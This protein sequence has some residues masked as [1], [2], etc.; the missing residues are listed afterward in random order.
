MDP[1]KQIE[2]RFDIVEAN[3]QKILKLIGGTPK[4][5]V[6]T[7]KMICEEYHVSRSTVHN[8]RKKGLLFPYSIGSLIRFK[9]SDVDEWISG[10]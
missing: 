1:F 3:Q 9:R 4:P 2:K 7:T 10:R 5:N 8:A 6:L